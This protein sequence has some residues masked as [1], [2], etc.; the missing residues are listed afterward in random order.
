MFNS[1]VLQATGIELS[2]YSC[3]VSSLVSSEALRCS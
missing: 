2:P 3:E 1:K